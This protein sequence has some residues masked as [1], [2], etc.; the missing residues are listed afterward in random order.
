[1]NS[2]KVKGKQTFFSTVR[3]AVFQKVTLDLLRVF[4][5]SGSYAYVWQSQAKY[6]IIVNL[7]NSLSHSIRVERAKIAAPSLPTIRRIYLKF[8]F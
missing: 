7:A 6:Q 8:L 3:I 4:S 1:M 2:G 5:I